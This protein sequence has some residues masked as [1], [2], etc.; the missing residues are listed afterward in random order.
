MKVAANMLPD[1]NDGVFFIDLTAITDLEFVP[2]AIADALSL[3]SSAD[4]DL[5][6]IIKDTS[7]TPGGASYHCHF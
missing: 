6:H 2:S 7:Q 4:Q 3:S 1:F 5:T